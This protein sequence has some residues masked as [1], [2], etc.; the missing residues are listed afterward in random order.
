MKKIL[1][2]ALALTMTT[3]VG[4]ASTTGGGV[5]G[6]ERK[7]LMIVPSD[8]VLKLSLE[9]YNK[10]VS[11][12]NKSRLLDTNPA[13]KDRLIT[14]AAKLVNQV[15]IY[16]P[17]AKA[18]KWE[19]HT[20]KS[21]DLNAFVMSGGKIMFYTGIIDRLRLT[22][23]EIAAVMGHEISHALREHARERVSHQYATQMSMGLAA[24]FL[25][26]SQGQAQLASLV[27]S[28]GIEK[29]HGRTQE[30][31]AD[32]MGLEL[33]ARAGYN[34]AAAVTLWQKMAAANKNQVPQFLS[35]HPSSDNRISTLQSMIPKVMPLYQQSK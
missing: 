15:D 2:M 28:Y 10:R 19:V 31:E 7:Q 34:P 24:S 12:A 21:D 17:D 23:D 5:I 18:W 14:I 1:S 4:C 3:L 20:I 30:S 25:G 11:D 16:R 27:S 8:E 26:L 6:V 32:V 22:D 33:M 35:T 13:Q 29:P 9:S